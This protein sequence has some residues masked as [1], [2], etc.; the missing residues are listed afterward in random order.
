[1]AATG[2]PVLG[3]P[4]SGA[5]LVLTKVAFR[6]SCFDS[7]VLA[8]GFYFTQWVWLSH[9]SSPCVK[10]RRNFSKCR[11]PHSTGSAGR[12]H[13]PLSAISRSKTWLRVLP[14]LL[15]TKAWPVPA[16]KSSN[17]PQADKHSPN[18]RLAAPP[19]QAT[20]AS[21][22]AGCGASRLANRQPCWRAKSRSSIKVEKMGHFSPVSAQRCSRPG[23]GS[24][25][26]SRKPERSCQRTLHA[27]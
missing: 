21:K 16:L 24:S 27:K 20:T 9:K 15:P 11:A 26:Q 1:M 18:G 17:K 2:A 5:F 3:L 7:S 25:T 19:T 6:G 10:I 23:S 8:V 13:G 14:F 4:G 12:F 22:S